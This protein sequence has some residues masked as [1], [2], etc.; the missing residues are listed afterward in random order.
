MFGSLKNILS[1]DWLDNSNNH[2]IKLSTEYENTLWQIFSIYKIPN[3]SDYIQTSFNDS[4]SFDKFT[5][6]IIDRSKYNFNTSINYNDKILT[7][8]TCYNNDI[9]IVLHAKLI[10]RESR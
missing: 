1:N 3:T 10:K 2:I 9:K 4:N 5:K 8:S 6:M 7:L